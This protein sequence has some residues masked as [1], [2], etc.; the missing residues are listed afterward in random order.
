MAVNLT[1]FINI[2]KK[3]GRYG[4]YGLNTDQATTDIL[5]SINVRGA[6]IW[7][8]ADWKWQRELLAFAVAPGT[9][10][11]NVTAKSGNAI[12]RILNVIPNDPTVNPAVSGAPLEEMEIGDFFLKCP[13]ANVLPDLPSKYINIGQN[14][15]GQWQIILWPSPASAF[16]MSG[17]AKAVLYTYLQSDVVAN[18]PIKYFP[19]GVVL[20]ALMAG[21]LIDIGRIMGMSAETALAAE[22]AWELKIKHLEGEQIGVATDNTPKTAPMPDR[23]VQRML[24][25]N[26]RGTRVC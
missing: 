11:Y 25:R 15:A 18:T 10:Q 2:L 14:A 20:D 24:N 4:T 17:F 8:A 9:T 16:T 22:Q 3:E 19:N 7:G 23:I 26:R 5:A 1:D 12:D 21:C 6:R 13:Q